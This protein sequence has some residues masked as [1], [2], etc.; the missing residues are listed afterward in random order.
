MSGQVQRAYSKRAY[1]KEKL[2]GFEKE[3]H[4][5]FNGNQ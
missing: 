3:P 1:G 4:A 5:E 2:K